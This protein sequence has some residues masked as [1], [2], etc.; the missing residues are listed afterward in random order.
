MTTIPDKVVWRNGVG[1]L[2]KDSV[3]I[4]TDEFKLEGTVAG[5]IFSESIGIPESIML[6]DYW[7][8]FQTEMLAIQVAV[9]VV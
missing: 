8:V 9:R 6:P 7:S 4:F 1:H 5:G 3:Q 2:V